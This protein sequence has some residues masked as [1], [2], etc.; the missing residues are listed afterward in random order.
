[1][2]FANMCS[3]FPHMY[4][5]TAFPTSHAVFNLF[6]HSHP[7]TPYSIIFTYFLPKADCVGIDLA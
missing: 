1:M 6:T 2:H 5:P 7:D 4:Y 3:L